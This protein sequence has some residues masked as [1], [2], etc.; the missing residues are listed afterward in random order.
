MEERRKAWGRVRRTGSQYQYCRG[1]GRLEE[2]MTRPEG[3]A[4]RNMKKKPE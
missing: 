2:N 1:A 3:K 4:A